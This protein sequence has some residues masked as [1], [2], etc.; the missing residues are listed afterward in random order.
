MLSTPVH[1]LPAYTFCGRSPYVVTFHESSTDLNRSTATENDGSRHNSQ[2]ADRSICGPVPSFSPTTA[3]EAVENSQASVDD[4]LLGLLGAYHQLAIDTFNTCSRGPTHRSLIDTGEGY[5][6][7]GADFSHATPRPFQPAVS[8]FHLRAPP[9]LKLS[10]NSLP[11][12][13]KGD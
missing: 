13:L 9:D 10:I 7:G 5:N 6:L 2:H 8:P 12:E 3:S 4:K 11:S 1:V